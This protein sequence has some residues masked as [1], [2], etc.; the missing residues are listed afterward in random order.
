MRPEFL[1][2]GDP[3]WAAFLEGAPHDF[4]HLPAYVELCARMDGGEAAAFLATDGGRAMLMPL[5]LRPV[6][7][8]PWRDACAPYGYPCP[9]FRGEPSPEGVG[10]FL[11]AFAAAG[12]AAGLV[13]AFFRFHPLLPVPEGPFE[14]FGTVV[15][16]GQTVFLDLDLPPEELERQTRVNHRADARKLLA[17]GFRVEVDGWDRLG[18]F[19][20][21]YAETMAYRGS[22][23]AYRFGAA[24]F[25]DLRACLGERLHLCMVVGP[26]GEAA[27]GGLF[28]NMDGLMQFHLAG[29]AAAFRR[30]GPAKLMLLAMRD[31]ARAWGARRLHL[32][33]GVGCAEDS[34]AFFKQGFS[35]LRSRFATYRMVLLPRVYR[36]LAGDRTGDFFPAYRHS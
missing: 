1:R 20:G 5:V 27:A 25:R 22:G 3:A 9:L 2:P 8:G 35:R 13:S 33:G 4:Y 6:P 31:Q 19:A 21:I 36:D 7:G 23:A 10:A 18:E 34:L 15:D 30:A 11:E 17:G 28:T 16:H 29:T 12:A 26:G 32:G 14:R 24:Y